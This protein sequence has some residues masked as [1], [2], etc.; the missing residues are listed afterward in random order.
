M[1][2]GITKYTCLVL[3]AAHRRAMPAMYRINKCHQRGGGG[4]VVTTNCTNIPTRGVSRIAA[5]A[6]K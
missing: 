1:Y 4:P 5:Y 2:A 3:L 6:G